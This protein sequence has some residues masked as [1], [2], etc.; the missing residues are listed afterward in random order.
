M[1]LRYRAAVFY[2]FIFLVAA[3]P[4]YAAIETA[5]SETNNVLQKGLTLYEIDQELARIQKQEAELQQKLADTEQRIREQE[6]SAKHT[7]LH[8]GQVLRAYYMGDRDAVWLLVF[9]ISSLSDALATL[10]YLLMIVGN[11]RLALQ[12]FADAVQELNALKGSLLQSQLA[13]AQTKSNY[14]TQK[15]QMLALQKELDQELA[16]L[17]EP[18]QAQKQIADLTKD[19]QEKGVPL[20]RTY[21][22]ALAAAM[23]QL[24]ELVTANGGKNNNLI[25]NGLNYTFQMTD[26]ELNTFLRQ[27]N[28][29]FENMAFKFTGGK[30]VAE[31]KHDDVAISIKGHYLFEPEKNSNTI[32]FVTDELQ[33]NAFQLP[34]T[35]IAAL[36]KEFDLGIYPQNLA[37]FLQVTEM[38][39]EE[40]KL[41][42]Q[43]KF[44]F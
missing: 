23:K 15:E 3:H 14:I 39:M 28:P 18:K 33:F 6:A 43:L 9:H 4:L 11:D 20:F 12:R 40:G 26:Q 36:E 8:A 19:W 16:K 13:L 38:T 7:R 17:S 34:S 24:P 21:F 30:V 32:R 29:L 41:S 27:K 35:T 1:K 31:G 44:K 42:I 2:L 10:D 37:A 22:Q 5:S 25:M